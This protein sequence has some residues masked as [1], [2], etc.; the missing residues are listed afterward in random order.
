MR[1]NSDLSFVVTNELAVRPV[2]ISF[3][4]TFLLMHYPLC[5]EDARPPCRGLEETF[6]WPHGPYRIIL[7]FIF[8][9]STVRHSRAALS[10]I[11]GSAARP[12]LENRRASVN[13]RRKVADRRVICEHVRKPI[14]GGLCHM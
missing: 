3:T 6:L 13:V 5:A 8:L 7:T 2:V 4:I 14:Y 10:M 11:S 9:K 1:P 12:R